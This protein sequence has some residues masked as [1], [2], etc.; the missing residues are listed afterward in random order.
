MPTYLG[1]SYRTYETFQG[2]NQLNDQ[3]KNLCKRID[4]DVIPVICFHL[5][6][7]H[8]LKKVFLLQ[9]VG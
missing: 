1:M 2:I 4:W 9:E 8:L 3:I 5:A 6:M 7:G